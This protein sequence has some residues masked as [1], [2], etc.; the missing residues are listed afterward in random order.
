MRLKK[1]DLFWVGSLFLIYFLYWIPMIHFQP[2]LSTGD[3]GRDLYAFE[4]VL[5]G[6]RPCRDYWWQYGPLMLLYYAFWFL[7][8]GINLLSVRIGLAGIYLLCGLFSYASLRLFTSAPTAWLASLGF[9]NF[10]MGW[11]FNHIG[12]VPFLLASV[13][14]L[15]KFFLTQNLRWPYLGVLSLVLTAL[16]KTSIGIPCFFA[17]YLSLL[18]YNEFLGPKLNARPPLARKHFILLP[19]LFAVPV[20]GVYIFMYWGLTSR[21]LQQCL[22]LGPQYRRTLSTP[23]MNVKHLILRFTVWERIRL[24]SLGAFTLLLILAGLG[25]RK[26]KLESLQQDA[27]LAA[28]ISLVFYALA[29]SAEYVM[30][31]EVIYR[32]DFWFFPVLILVLGFLAERASSLFP[33]PWKIAFGALIF[34]AL[35]GLPFWRVKEALAERIPDRYLDLPRG[36]V[37]VGGPLVSLQTIKEGAQFLRENSRKDQSFLAIPYEPLYGFLSERRHALPEMIFMVHMQ[38][39][40]DDEEKWI[41]QM[42]ANEVPWVLISNRYRS[43]EA[44]IGEFGKTHCRKLAAYI[45]DH[46]REVKTLG[47]WGSDPDKTHAI[48]LLKRA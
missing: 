45:F 38:I 25:F 18:I 43:E 39:Q 8:G 26:R 34:V 3:I 21:E 46:Y 28:G 7:V 40:E 11:T 44:G 35:A 23:W 13:F 12:A 22:T 36:K 1:F 30:M 29:S 48:K 4:S 19:L 5:H 17:F 16:V 10:S 31:G 6:L 41:T 9:L 20:A 33:R 14:C 24:W 37:Y 27:A 2:F 15:W 32:F 47:P 42:E